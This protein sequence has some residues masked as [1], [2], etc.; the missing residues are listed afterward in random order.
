MANKV[1]TPYVYTFLNQIDIIAVF[2]D[3]TAGGS[4][5]HVLIFNQYCH[6]IARPQ[7]TSISGNSD[8]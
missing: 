2:E 5:A 7:L 4:C 6:R 3:N 8:T 1:K